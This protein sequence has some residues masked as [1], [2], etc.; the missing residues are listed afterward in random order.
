MQS[1][2]VEMLYSLR[3][4][5]TSGIRLAYACMFLHEEHCTGPDSLAEERM[6][7][8]LMQANSEETQRPGDLQTQAD[9]DAQT[10]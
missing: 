9:L 3:C 8:A 10:A 2:P 1:G 5:G 6:H 7:Q 4:G